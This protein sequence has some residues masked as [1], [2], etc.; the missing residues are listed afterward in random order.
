MKQSEEK[1]VRLTRIDIAR[2]IAIFLVVLGHALPTGGD[3]KRYVYYFHMP[4]FFLISGLLLKAEKPASFGEALSV[5]GKKLRAYYVPYVVWGLIYAQFGLENIFRILYGSRP[6]IMDA[7][8]VS[9]L[10]F[11]P[12]M[13]LAALIC[14][15][16]L[17][18]A[19]STGHPPVLTGVCA[20]CL[21]AVSLLLPGIDKGYPL[22]FDIALAGA[23]FMLLGRMIRP[24][25]DVLVNRKKLTVILAMAFS[26]LFALSVLFLTPADIHVEMYRGGYGNLFF[27][28]LNALSG[29]FAVILWAMA[30]DSLPFK[31][32]AV[33]VG[34]NTLGILLIHRRMVKAVTEWM[35]AYP[36]MET[37]P[38]LR[39]LAAAL[40]TLV[41]SLLIN[42]LIKLCLPELV[43]AR[44]SLQTKK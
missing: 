43:G 6:A 36:Y 38:H 21:F 25:T 4:L 35:K 37:H 18:L 34:Q 44:R 31:G 40:C 5:F 24:L 30:A 27:F 11:L 3:A 8:S 23:A 28:F 1:P 20:A 29:S 22:G 7:D 42:G 39:A 16:L 14:P 26:V 15:P 13:L 32:A 41:L 33:Y 17:S 19:E 12:V 9:S 10:W 2:G